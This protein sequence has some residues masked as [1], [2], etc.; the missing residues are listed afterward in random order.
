MEQT[1]SVSELTS[2]LKD[3][4]EGSFGVV[5]VEG[6]I[7]NFRPSSTGHWYFTLK[8]ESAVIQAVMFRNRIMSLEFEPQDGQRVVLVGTL[9]LYEKR[10]SYQI[11]CDR[12]EEAGLGKILQELEERKQ[13]LALEGLFSAQNKLAMPQFPSRIVLV[14]SPTGAALKDILHVLARRNAG[15]DIVIVPS[16]VQGSEAGARLA[17]A[18]AIADRHQLGDVII[19]TRGGGSLEDLLPFSEE[20]LVRAIAACKTPIISAVGHEIDTSLSD[21]AADLRAPTPSAAAEI[22]AANRS[23]VVNRIVGAGR[24]IIHALSMHLAKC[25]RGLRPFLADSLE[26]TFRQFMQPRMQRLD[27]GK[28]DLIVGMQ[29]YCLYLRQTLDSHALV[30]ES[31]SPENVLKRGYA[32]VKQADQILSSKPEG[33]ARLSIQ[34]HDGVR[35]ADLIQTDSKQGDS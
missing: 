5:R 7:S 23:E 29:H 25:R 15:L 18:I 11:V 12:M 13:R 20:I 10:G 1:Q 9:S 30:F 28:E 24:N 27:D 14:T 21:L 31:L 6:E 2:M 34:W 3:L 17:Q 19:L 35:Q 32:I 4:I 22:V 16:P 26:D 33:Q 8:D